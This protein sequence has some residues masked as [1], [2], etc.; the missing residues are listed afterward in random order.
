MSNA[1][2]YHVDQIFVYAQ[3]L[4]PMNYLNQVVWITLA[5]SGLDRA[6]AL[7]FAQ[8]GATAAA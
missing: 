8:Q 6:M 1:F 7:E 5:S 4:N 3:N 2:R